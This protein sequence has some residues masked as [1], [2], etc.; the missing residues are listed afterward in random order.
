M[1]ARSWEKLGLLFGPDVALPW[2]RSHAQ[3]P[4]VVPAPEG[5]D[6]FHAYFASRDADSR[7]HIGMATLELGDRPRVLSYARE[8]LLAPGPIGGFDADGVYPSSL[9]RCGDEDRLYYIG[10][11]RGA[12]GPLFVSAIGLATAITGSQRFT[13]TSSAPLVDRGPHDPCLVTSPCVYRQG[14]GW[15]MAY[16]S[17]VRWTRDAGQL[18]SH[19]HLKMAA[20]ADGLTWRRDGRIAIDFKNAAETN[21]AR[22]WVLRTDSGW[23]MWFCAASPPAKYRMG[24]AESPDGDVWTRRDDLAGLE[25]SPDPSAFDSEMVAYPCV[26]RHRDAEFLFY[27]GNGFGRD[28][29]AV[30]RRQIGA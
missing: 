12:E 23:Q 15:R 20:S 7:S 11:L 28:G 22:P 6:R 1:S 5:G 27:N 25:P 8:S 21:I 24:Y 17:G 10:W 9:V 4:L 19:Y 2:M 13:R 16:V 26:V 3:L 29:F 30:A 14:S 18:H